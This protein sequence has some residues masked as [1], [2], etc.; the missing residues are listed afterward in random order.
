MLFLSLSARAVLGKQRY[1]SSSLH[2]SVFCRGLKVHITHCDIFEGSKRSVC[3]SIGAEVA[4]KQ[5]QLSSRVKIDRKRVLRVILKVTLL[6]C[7]GHRR[8]DPEGSLCDTGGANVQHCSS[9][10]IL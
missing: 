9:I 8:E 7:L 2:I 1:I 3:A 5:Q 10:L 6:L 4:V